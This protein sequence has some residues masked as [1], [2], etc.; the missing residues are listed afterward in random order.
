MIKCYLKCSHPEW[1]NK[2]AQKLPVWQ[3][4]G[5]WLR[6]FPLLWAESIPLWIRWCRT[7]PTLLRAQLGLHTSLLQPRRQITLPCVPPILLGFNRHRSLPLAASNH[8]AGSLD[9]TPTLTALGSDGH[10]CQLCAPCPPRSN[11]PGSRVLPV[12]ATNAPDRD[13]PRTPPALGRR[14]KPDSSHLSEGQ[15]VTWAMGPVSKL[16]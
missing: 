14:E 13:S 15:K 9:F 11:Q 2:I 10:C 8:P 16:Q 5:A 4:A 6:F 3:P 1:K 12:A 7:L